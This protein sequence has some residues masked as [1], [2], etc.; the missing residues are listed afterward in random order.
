MNA[1]LCRWALDPRPEVQA[2]DRKGTF[3]SRSPSRSSATEP[4]WIRRATDPP[5]FDGPVRRDVERDHHVRIGPGIRGHGSRYRDLPGS[6]D[7]PLVVREHRTRDHHRSDRTQRKLPHRSIHNSPHR[8]VTHGE[9]RSTVEPMRPSALVRGR[10]RIPSEAT[11]R[12]Q[13]R[14]R[15]DRLVT[16]R[17]RA[18]SSRAPR[19]LQ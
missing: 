17:T 7:R 1:V 5:L 2:A 18:P 10:Q 13:R 3:P 6:I 9:A 14:K 15:T 4:C 16:L 11:R 8:R 19:R 12:R